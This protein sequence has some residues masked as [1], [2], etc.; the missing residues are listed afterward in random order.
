VEVEHAFATSEERAEMDKATYLGGDERGRFTMKE[1]ERQMNLRDFG[2]EEEIATILASCL[3][4]E[5][6]A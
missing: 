6:G 5:D 2:W 4:G 3:L 1:T